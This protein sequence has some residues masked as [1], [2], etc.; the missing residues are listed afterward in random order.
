MDRSNEGAVASPP[1]A[2][3]EVFPQPLKVTRDNVAELARLFRNAAK[4]IFAIRTNATDALFLREPWM[5]DE[6][7]QWM[8]EFFHEYFLHG[9]H[10]FVNVLRDIEKQHDAHA[11][12][13]EG[14]ARQYGLLEDETVPRFSGKLPR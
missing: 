1:A 13:L 10:S 5:G 6:T 4:Q 11:S 7:S 12:A 9:E 3:P 8:R 2:A 14:V